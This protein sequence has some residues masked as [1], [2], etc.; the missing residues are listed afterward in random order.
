MKCKLKYSQDIIHQHIDC[1]RIQTLVKHKTGKVLINLHLFI[2]IINN[3]IVSKVNFK[4]EWSNS[5]GG[6]Y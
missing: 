3:H 1:Q 2:I 4:F 6:C 5:L